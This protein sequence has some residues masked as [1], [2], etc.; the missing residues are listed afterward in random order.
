VLPFL[1]SSHDI[2]CHNKLAC[3][4]WLYDL[5]EQGLHHAHREA[6]RIPLTPPPPLQ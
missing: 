3:H 5:L 6:M 1:Q 2:L 4:H